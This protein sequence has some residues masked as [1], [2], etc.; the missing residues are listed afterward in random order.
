M[1]SDSSTGLA[2][3]QPL[4]D[5]RGG[6]RGSSPRGSYGR[7]RPAV[8][9]DVDLVGRECGLA[10][11]QVFRRR[12]GRWLEDSLRPAWLGRI[13]AG[14]PVQG[15]SPVPRQKARETREEG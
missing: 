6:G 14:T 7:G 12:V 9:P 15:A 1:G 4:A 10:Y 5:S 2:G 8:G 3:I 13:D 11:W